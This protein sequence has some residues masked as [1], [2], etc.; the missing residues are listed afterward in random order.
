MYFYVQETAESVDLDLDFVYDDA[1][2]HTNEIAELY[3]Y[4]EQYEL[5]VNLT[6]SNRVCVFQ[7][8]T[9]NFNYYTEINPIS[10]QRS[11]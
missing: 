6:V 7:L 10:E 2:I 1:D 4:T 3:S 8:I 9:S 5:H 11:N